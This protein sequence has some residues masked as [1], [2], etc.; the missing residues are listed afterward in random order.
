MQTS[1][2]P[3]S[4]AR[5]HCSP[6]GDFDAVNRK[7]RRCRPARGA[8]PWRRQAECL[9]APGPR[10]A[11]ARSHSWPACGSQWLLYEPAARPAT[12]AAAALLQG[13]CRD[14]KGAAPASRGRG[15]GRGLARKPPSF[16]RVPG[17]RSGPSFWSKSG[18]YRQ[19]QRSVPRAS[20]PLVRKSAAGPGQPP[21]LRR[22]PSPAETWARYASAAAAGLRGS[23]GQRL[24]PHGKRARDGS[25]VRSSAR[26]LR[27]AGTCAR[28]VLGAAAPLDFSVFGLCCESARSSNRGG[29][30]D[31]RFCQASGSRWSG[32]RAPCVQSVGPDNT[33]VAGLRHGARTAPPGAAGM[34]GARGP[35]Q[36]RSLASLA[37]LCAAESGA[38]YS[39]AGGFVSLKSLPS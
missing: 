15:G 30:A 21:G 34:R 38:S 37:G 2:R 28:A 11:S 3:E 9:S 36:S 26:A 10:A 27:T 19:R 35:A 23:H 8:Y 5:V 39:F 22:P 14:L 12:L 20:P 25:S 16:F 33:G 1:G 4:R 13:G 18:V 7:R 6:N 31:S 32:R 29:L 17:S 24:G